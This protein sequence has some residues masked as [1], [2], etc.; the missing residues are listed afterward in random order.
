MGSLSE[1]S[2][3]QGGSRCGGGADAFA[4]RGVEVALDAAAIAFVVEF[5][6]FLDAVFAGEVG[7]AE[8]DEGS[9]LRAGV[10]G[11]AFAEVEV[12]IRGLTIG[13]VAAA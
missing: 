12:R 2:G 10:A 9:D 6:A 8:A 7:I 1:F 13:N 5:G 11:G 4:L 3:G